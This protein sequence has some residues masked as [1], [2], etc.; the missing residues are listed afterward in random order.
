MGILSGLFDGIKTVGAVLAAPSTGGAS[1]LGP[2]ISGGLGFLGQRSANEANSDA[3]NAQMAF[4][5]RMSGTS[6]Q[7]AVADMRAA[8][9]NPALAFS[10]GGASTPSGSAPVFQNTLSGAASS[11]LQ[12][13]TVSSQL[14]NMEADTALKRANS[15]AALAS[16]QQTAQDI[17]MN[18]P[19]AD[20]R[21]S[22]TGRVL[23]WINNVSQA[24]QGTLDAG[25]SARKLY[26]GARRP[27]IRFRYGP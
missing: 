27:A 4:Q 22:T 25:H 10:Q 2:I 8:G 5:E 26:E 7:R 1:L 13:A 12:A 14:K 9:L 6:Y 16:A 24:V 11:A 23:N 21:G 17:Q 20:L 18:R 15:A 19:Q 3:A